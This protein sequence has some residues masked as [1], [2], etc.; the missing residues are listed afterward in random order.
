MV[1]RPWRLWLRV[2]LKHDGCCLKSQHPEE[3]DELA[4]SAEQLVAPESSSGPE[5]RRR[6]CLA[7]IQRP[8]R[9][10]D[11]RLKTIDRRHEDGQDRQTDDNGGLPKQKEEAVST[12]QERWGGGEK[13]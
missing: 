3:R 1:V 8:M 4:R 7:T 11:L 6:K 5:G 12:R 2:R 13:K 10:M 9:N